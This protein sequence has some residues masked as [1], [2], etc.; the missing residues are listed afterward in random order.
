MYWSELHLGDQGWAAL[1]LE[2]QE[3]RTLAKEPWCWITAL[4]GCRSLRPM[5]HRTRC[6]LV[7]YQAVQ[8]GEECAL[9]EPEHCCPVQIV[10]A[11]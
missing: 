6:S 2:A 5:Q 9:L 8:G 11:G 3:P 4:E 10:F 1:G 7:A